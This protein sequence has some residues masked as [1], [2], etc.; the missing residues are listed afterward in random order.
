MSK[1]DSSKTS[2]ATRVPSRSTHRARRDV[3]STKTRF[4]MV[5]F[6]T[7]LIGADLEDLVELANVIDDREVTDVPQDEMTRVGSCPVR[8]VRD[9]AINLGVRCC[10]DGSTKLFEQARR[11]LGHAA[12]VLILGLVARKKIA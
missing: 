5:G 9:R 7:L 6:Q 2:V 3:G 12:A 8:V 1:I 10:H 4:D 11:Q